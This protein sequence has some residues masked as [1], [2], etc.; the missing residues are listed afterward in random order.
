M[1]KDLIA[2]SKLILMDDISEFFPEARKI[3]IYKSGMRI[4]VGLKDI[5]C[6]LIISD[7]MKLIVEE[8]IFY[9]D[10]FYNQKKLNEKI[11]EVNLKI[12]QWMQGIK[13]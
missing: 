8:A 6:W 9:A 2:L 12:A 11:N 1:N 10:P 3:S 7:D 13:K 5:D 4:S